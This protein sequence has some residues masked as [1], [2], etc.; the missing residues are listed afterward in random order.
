MSLTMA[1]VTG[2]M[3]LFILIFTE[4]PVGFLMALL[5][6]AGFAGLVTVDAALNLTGQI[7][8]HSGISSRLF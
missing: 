4:M 8:F 6:A 1:G 2:L 3:L 7:A 5:G